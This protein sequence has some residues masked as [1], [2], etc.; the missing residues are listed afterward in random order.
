ME[1]RKIRFLPLWISLVCIIAFVLQL[2]IPG[3][4]ELFM[5]TPD[6][7][8]MPWQFLTAVFLHGGVVHLLYNLFALVLFGLMLEKMIG[9]KRFLILFLLSGIAANIFSFF[10]YPNQSALGASGA[11]MAVIGVVAVL[12]P[13]MTIWAFNLPMPMFIAAL[14]W[15][16]GSV[17]GIFGLGDQGVGHLA[18]LSGIVIGIAY[19][20]W[21]RLRYKNRN[22]SASARFSYSRKINLPED[23]MRRWED[24]HLRR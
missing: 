7:L 15:V 1:T 10:A 5:L 16:G 11:I 21:L 17:L 23:E 8:I 9:S 2:I 3:F 20:F 13:M 22:S 12:R 4:T 18:H 14:I 6:S 24:Y 19:G